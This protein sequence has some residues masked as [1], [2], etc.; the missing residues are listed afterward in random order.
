MTSCCQFCAIKILF[1]KS[2]AY[3]DV[4]HGVLW[5]VARAGLE[6]VSSELILSCHVRSLLNVPFPNAIY[7]GHTG[8]ELSLTVVVYVFRYVFL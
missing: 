2:F 1:F 8:I 3:L 5:A 4:C 6:L 7:W